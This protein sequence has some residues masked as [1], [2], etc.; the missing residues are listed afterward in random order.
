MDYN[1]SD[2]K[3]VTLPV[4]FGHALLVLLPSLFF[5]ISVLLAFILYKDLHNPLSVLYGFVPILAIYNS[6]VTGPIGYVSLVRIVR[7]CDC[8]LDIL[9]RI[10]SVAIHRLLYP[11]LFAELSLLQLLIVKCGKSLVSYK[12]TLILVVMT[13]ILYMPALLLLS[14][15]FVQHFV[16][17][18]AW[19]QIPSMLT[20]PLFTRLIGLYKHQD[21]SQPWQ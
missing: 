19:V 10:S 13:A 2:W 9:H 3:A 18:C 21:G 11:A 14:A 20:A 8:I 15:S 5:N 6:L 7:S 4:V 16:N 12:V 1:F 17:M